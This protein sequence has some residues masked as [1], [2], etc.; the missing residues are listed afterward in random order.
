MQA[1][2]S[3]RTLAK[4]ELDLRVGNGA[5]VAALAVG[6]YSLTLSSGLVLELEN[7][8]YVPTITRNIIYVSCLDRKGLCFTI[9]NN[10]CSIYPK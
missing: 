3:S 9:E 10:C 1:L 2:R 7:C 5:K 8:Y 6:V 4:G